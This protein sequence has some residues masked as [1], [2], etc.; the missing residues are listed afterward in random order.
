MLA[1][2]RKRRLPLP[3][4]RIRLTARPCSEPPGRSAVPRAGRGLGRR[5]GA[6]RQRGPVPALRSTSGRPRS[7]FCA[8][9]QRRCKTTPNSAQWAKAV[10]RSRGCGWR[11][12]HRTMREG[13]RSN[14]RTKPSLNACMG[15][16]WKSGRR[17]DHAS[18]F[19]AQCRISALCSISATAA[20]RAPRGMLPKCATAIRRRPSPRHGR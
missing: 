9:G 7:R 4:V 20:R 1:S 2:S 16:S 5:G 3:P 12:R 15:L 18:I 19:R 10:L 17:R 11:R 13:A 14:E 6:A 8:R